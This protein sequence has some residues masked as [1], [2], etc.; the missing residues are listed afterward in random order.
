MDDDPFAD[1]ARFVRRE[2]DR[3]LFAGALLGLLGGFGMGSAE[4]KQGKK[5]K[6]KPCHVRKHGKCRKAP[7]DSICD[8]DGRC[9][10]GICNAKPDCVPAG[11]DCEAAT[12]CCS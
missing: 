5:K 10:A 12:P 2:T 7:D 4:A 9:L 6:C 8:G 3:R 11:A 1:L